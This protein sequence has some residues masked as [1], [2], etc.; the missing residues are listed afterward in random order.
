MDL[1]EFLKNLPDDALMSFFGNIV[2][3]AAFVL[4]IVA[5]VIPCWRRRTKLEC[6]SVKYFHNEKF[7]TFSIANKTE[8]PISIYRAHITDCE[9]GLSVELSANETKTIGGFEIQD[10]IFNTVNLGVFSPCPTHKYKIRLFASRG[11]K[12]SLTFT[13]FIKKLNPSTTSQEL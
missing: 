12:R 8:L 3:V 13:T 1:I 2:S 7:L 11:K 5:I 4:S 9:T 6:C 10:I